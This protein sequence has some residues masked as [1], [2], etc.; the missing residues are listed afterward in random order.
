MLMLE[1][2]SILTLESFRR[3]PPIVHKG[4]P[5]LQEEVVA[6][7][8]PRFEEAVRQAFRDQGYEVK[9]HP[10]YDGKG[11]DVDI[12]VSPPIDRFRLFLPD[13]GDPI[14]VQV[15]WKQGVDQD[16]EDAVKEIV[17]GV[18]FLGNNA[19]KYVI[20]SASRFTEN[21]KITAAENDVVLISGLQ[22]MCFLLGFPE[23][24][25]ED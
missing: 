3:L 22:T 7:N 25:R 9:Y 8:G 12:L 23:R 13:I 11:G 17:D 14:A 10:H 6:W 16:D 4:N 19:V 18:K 5:G 20:S 15:K 2:A 1:P 21:A 24:Y